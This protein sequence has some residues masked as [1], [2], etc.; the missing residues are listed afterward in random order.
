MYGGPGPD[1][2]SGARG[3]DVL[4][5][6][7]AND[8]LDGG[9]GNDTLYGG[10]GKDVLVGGSGEDTLTGGPGNDT[11]HARDGSQDLIDCGPGV[12][13]AI[14]DSQENE[15][16]T[17]RVRAVPAAQALR[18]AQRRAEAGLD[19]L[20]R[21]PAGVQRP[22]STTPRVRAPR[23]TTTTRQW[24]AGFA[25]AGLEPD[26]ARV[27]E[28]QVRF[29]GVEV[30]VLSAQVR[31]RD[32]GARGAR[33]ERSAAAASR[34]ARGPPGRRRTTC[35]RSGARRTRRSGCS[36]VRAA[37]PARSSGGRSCGRSRPRARRGPPPRRSPTAAAG[38]YRSAF[39]GTRFPRGST[40]P[41]DP[42]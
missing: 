7:A 10:P 39:T 13:T 42:V 11:F 31:E 4:R 38:H 33:C 16:S 24:P 17:A 34:S 23:R 22:G 36:S 28:P 6:K 18:L 15:S 35:C 1:L 40:P 32:V 26:R 19:E 20:H 21:L 14:V 12:D 9:P 5:G 27:V 8:H 3:D 41:S 29:C 2:L 37:A 25:V 30:E